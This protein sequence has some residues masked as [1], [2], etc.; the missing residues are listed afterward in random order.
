MGTKDKRIDAYIA[1]SADFAK[2]ILTHIR[3]VVHEACPDVEESIKWSTP[4][5]MYH[6]SPL[7]MMAAFKEHCALRF[8]NEKLVT[9]ETANAGSGGVFGH[10]TKVSDLPSKK[11]LAGY[12]KKAVALKEQGVK[13][14]QRPKTPKKE[15]A[16][17]D[18]LTAALEKNKKA[19]AAFE[20]FSPSHRREYVEWITEAKSD[21]TRARRMAQAIEWMSE[22]KSRHWKYQ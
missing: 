14:P 7:G 13:A 18:D 10:V 1:K 4:S 15:L 21:E 2:P 22:G 6:G 12:V 8:W 20:S 11:V 19:S 3:A 9:G 16:V 17:P 5:F